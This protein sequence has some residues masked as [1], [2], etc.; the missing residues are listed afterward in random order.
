MICGSGGSKSRLAKAAGAEPCGQRTF[1]S[2]CT[3]HTMFGPLLEVG[4]WKMARRVARRAFSSQNVQN[5]PFPDRFWKLV[6][7]GK[8]VSRSGAKHIFK[9]KCTKHTS[10]TI[11]GSWHVEK[12]HAAVA[13]STMYKTH[14]VRTTFRSSAVKQRHAAVARSTFPSE[15]VK[16]T[17]CSDHFFEVQMWKNGMWLWHEAH[18]QLN[19]LKT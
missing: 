18:L 6:A 7:C 1:K 3:K 5:T 4:T 11:F 10:Q 15:N 9:S 12:W 16:S 13:R 17:A 8:T 19:M 14:H 2:K